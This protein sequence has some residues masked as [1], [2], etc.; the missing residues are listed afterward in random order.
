MSL[1]HILLGLCREPSSGYDLKSVFDVAIRHFWAA[2]LSQIYP[3]L[4][5]L[6]RDGLLES[7][8]EPSSRGPERRVYRSTQAGRAAL[9]EWLVGGPD[10]RDERSVF[11]AQVFLLGELGSPDDSEAF[12]RRLREAFVERSAALAAV[13][14]SADEDLAASPAE[15]DH[16]EFHHQLTLRMGIHVFGARIA[17]CDEALR[18][19]AE[20]K[21]MRS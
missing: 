10:F 21:G 8:I 19:L 5:R 20:R 18:L 15:L 13:E 4:R 11:A 6:E 9:R 14:D 3:T 1:P 2:E 17:W 7:R 16:E 12:I